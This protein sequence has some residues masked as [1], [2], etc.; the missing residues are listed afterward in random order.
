MSLIP[1]RNAATVDTDSRQA[2][3]WAVRAELHDSHGHKKGHAVLGVDEEREEDVGAPAGHGTGKN[4][5]CGPGDLPSTGQP[6]LND[7]RMGTEER[8]AVSGSQRTVGHSLQPAGCS[9]A[10]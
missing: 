1:Q 4:R 10:D 3:G 6:A 9:P 7:T 2:D 5:S 8:Q